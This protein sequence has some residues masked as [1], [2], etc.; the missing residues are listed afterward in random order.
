MRNI[1]WEKDIAWDFL[2]TEQL[3]QMRASALKEQP[4]WEELDEALVKRGFNSITISAN[5][6]I[7]FAVSEIAGVEGRGECK[8]FNK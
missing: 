5:L 7:S 6:H 3:L 4:N 8:I 2:I 1:L